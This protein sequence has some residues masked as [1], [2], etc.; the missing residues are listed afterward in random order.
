MPLRSAGPAFLLP[1][2]ELRLREHLPAAWRRRH[3]ADRRL[4]GSGSERLPRANIPRTPRQRSGD[5]TRVCSPGFTRNTGG[6]QGECRGGVRGIP[7]PGFDDGGILLYSPYLREEIGREHGVREGIME[8]NEPAD[9]PP[10]AAPQNP[11]RNAE[12]AST[13]PFPSSAERA[14]NV[15]APPI[16]EWEERT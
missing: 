10:S 7:V 9:E 2:P 13:V 15:T 16:V 5:R 4:H 14:G 6:M 8:E 12:S 1:S 3:G 11:P